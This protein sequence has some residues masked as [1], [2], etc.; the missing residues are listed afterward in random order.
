MQTDR[1][2]ELTASDVAWVA[3]YF[4][5]PDADAEEESQEVVDQFFAAAQEQF[6]DEGLKAK[7]LALQ[8]QFQGRQKSVDAVE[9]N[10]W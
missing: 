6:G 7:Q 2:A 3:R 1:A 9:L 4:E 5:D 8:E 10:N